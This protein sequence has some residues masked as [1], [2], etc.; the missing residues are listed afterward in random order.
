MRYYVTA[1]SGEQGP[2]EEE[3]IR[4]WLAAGTMPANALVRA[5]HEAISVIASSV[6]PDEVAAAPPM[7][8]TRAAPPVTGPSVFDSPIADGG[9]NDW[10]HMNQGSFASGFVFGFFCGC[11]ALLVSYT[12]SSMGSETKRGVRVGFAVGLAIGML[13]RLLAAASQ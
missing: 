6:F 9:S 4:G 3:H 11:I 10:V 8:P 13:L 7:P 1:P 12:S 5:E 2:Y